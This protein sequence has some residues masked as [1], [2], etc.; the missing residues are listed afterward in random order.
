MM[1]QSGSR[2]VPN[3]LDYVLIRKLGAGAFGQV[4]HASGPGGLDVALKFIPLDA[5]VF[6][7][8]RRSLEVMRSIRHPNLVSLFGAW[9]KDNWLILAMELCDRSLQDRL[10]EALDQK[11]PGIPVTEL[12]GYVRDAANGL[13]ALNANQ[14]QHR[15][16]KPAN[17]LLLNSGVKVA[18][19]GMAKALEQTVA[20]NSGAGTIAY[21]APECFKGQLTQQSD[22]YSLAVTYYHLRTGR[23]LFKGDQAQIM[24]AHLEVEPNLSHLPPAEGAVLARVLS[25]EPGK[26]WRNCRV[27]VNELIKAKQNAKEKPHLVPSLR[28]KLDKRRE[29]LPVEPPRN[30]TN[31]LGMQFVF[32]PAATFWM[33]ERGQ[34][35]QVE[36]PH[37]FYIGIHPVTQGQWQALMCNNPSWFSRPGR[38]SGRVGSIPT[39]DFLESFRDGSLGTGADRV[40]GIAADELKDFPVESVSCGDGGEFDVET[41]IEKLNAREP[42]SEWVYRL[43]T[44]AEWEY[45][46]RG[47]ATSQHDCSFD[48]YFNQPTNDA[49]SHQANF[50]G[51]YPP[52]KGEM[53][54]YP[55]RTTK[56]G[57]YEA[58]RLGVFDMHGNG[59]RPAN[60]V[61]LAYSSGK[62]R[63][64]R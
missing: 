11:L 52:G 58:N 59:T 22:Q 41:F 56:I 46:C 19:F 20:S 47:G 38:S 16:V 25:K 15:D 54:P 63:L 55:A 33:G 42:N 18:D 29:V 6:A 43:P 8:E 14:V 21:I 17:L 27:F 60:H 45:C 3:C 26:R 62:P 34:Q 50:D 39:D 24:Y 31:S 9:H 5:R 28:Q 61:S 32:V 48:F 37:A 57:S 51:N 12:L 40:G 35:Q 64:P 36:I 1:L 44:E 49:S 10:R 4:W 2:P 13:D 53:G 7:S 23:L 30:F